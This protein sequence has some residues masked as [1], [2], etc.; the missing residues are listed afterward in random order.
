MI[1]HHIFLYILRFSPYILVR[2]HYSLTRLHMYSLN[3]VQIIGNLT[4]DPE[5][6]QTGS[7]QTVATIGVATNRAWK[8]ASGAKQ[9]Q[10]EYHN[11]VVWSRLAEICGQYLK[12]GTKVYFEGRLQTRSWEDESGKKN[13]RTEIVAED[14]IILSSKDM[15]INLESSSKTPRSV[16]K[17]VEN[18]AAPVQ[19]VGEESE[20]K[21]SVED[22]PF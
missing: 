12:K 9:E 20:E 17:P 15:G 22:L 6:R 8:D 1:Y 4:R 18:T 5:V 7:G 14:M 13:Y 11:I 10:V 21:I 2:N 19:T 16:N 3:K